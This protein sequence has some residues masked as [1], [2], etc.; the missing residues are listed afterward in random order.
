MTAFVTLAAILYGFVALLWGGVLYALTS[1][2]G[3]NNLA[4]SALHG[5]AWPWSLGRFLL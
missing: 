3:D 1:S 2:G 4:R 5:I